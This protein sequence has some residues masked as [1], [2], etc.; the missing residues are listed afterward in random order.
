MNAPDR[1]PQMH[2]ILI[3]DDHPV[4]RAGIAAVLSQEPDLTVCGEASNEADTLQLARRLKPDL[5]IL[6]LS[7]EGTSGT[8]VL[9]KLKHMSPNLRILVLSMHDEHVHAEQCLR[10]GAQGYL[11]KDQA[12]ATLI[13]AVRAVLKDELFVSDH[14]RTVLLK[15][16]S[17]PPHEHAA[18]NG[19]A[20]TVLTRTEWMVLELVGMGFSSRIIAEKLNRSIKTVNA[21]RANIQQKL[22][23]SDSAA[24]VRY[25]INWTQQGPDGAVRRTPAMV[26]SGKCLECDFWPGDT[27]E[28]GSCD[29]GTG[30]NIPDSD[31]KI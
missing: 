26:R 24:L 2:S 6:D 13:R 22:Q 15:G 23:L 9:H 12:P 31:I 4:M 30:T 8:A 7:L 10:A 11:M 27:E 1:K 21:H 28:E 5:V 16:L 29:A 3:I 17:R 19:E 25:A 14:M 20:P 18:P